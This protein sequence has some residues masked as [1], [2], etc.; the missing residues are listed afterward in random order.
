M[1]LAASLPTS[2]PY[3]HTTVC[4]GR[5]LSLFDPCPCL[6]CCIHPREEMTP[7]GKRCRGGGSVSLG[8]RVGDL[9]AADPSDGPGPGVP[10]KFNGGGLGGAEPF[11]WNGN[12][13]LN[14]W[15]SDG[16]V[17]SASNGS[18]SSSPSSRENVAWRFGGSR[19]P[20][21]L[22]GT[23]PQLS[24]RIVKVDRASQE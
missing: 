21:W 19:R 8:D 2:D 12:G 10:E 3:L 13:T 14:F 24:A 15:V 5:R 23:F 11:F 18:P 9:A 22:A 6:S 17:G 1:P 16:G 20:A 7:G 4:S